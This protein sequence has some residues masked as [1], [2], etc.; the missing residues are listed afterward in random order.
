MATTEARDNT[1]DWVL[2]AAARPRSFADLEA[3]ID[4]ALTISKASEA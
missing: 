2:P 4:L 1:E 3:R